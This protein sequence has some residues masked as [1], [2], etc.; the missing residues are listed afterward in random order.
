M[1]TENEARLELRRW[2][3]LWHEAEAMYAGWAHEHGVSLNALMLLCA[4]MDEPESSQSSLARELSMPKQTV[5][6]ILKDFARRGYAELR[7][8]QEDRRNKRVELSAAGR[9][10]ALSL[11]E[12]LHRRELD[13]MER[14]GFD[15]I[16]ALNDAQELFNALFKEG[17]HGR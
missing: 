11:T 3:A 15:R 13:I 2:Y 6:T 16:K 7:P 9:E 10:Y 5:N 17:G 4:L 12:A 14:M 1:Q 8:E